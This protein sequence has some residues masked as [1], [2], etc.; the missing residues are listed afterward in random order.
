MEEKKINKLSH[1]GLLNVVLRE[2]NLIL[3]N[4]IADRMELTNIRREEF[5]DKY[6]KVTYYSPK[7]I[8]SKK[9]ENL[10]NIITKIK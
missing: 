4:K 3:L 7:V 1:I 8:L 9:R 2:Q 10:Q 5:I 6:H